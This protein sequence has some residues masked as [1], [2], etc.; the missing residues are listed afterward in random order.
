MGEHRMSKKPE[1][2]VVAATGG[3]VAGSSVALLAL[4]EGMPQWAK[5]LIILFG[6]PL[7]TFLGGYA[8]RQTG[9][10]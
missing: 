3:S 5:V 7:A 10:R 2:K 4:T 1:P 8:A 6:P 9:P